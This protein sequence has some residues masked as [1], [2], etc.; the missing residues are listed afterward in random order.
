MKKILFFIALLGG[1]AT[2]AQ[3]PYPDSIDVLHY[4]IHLD[5]GHRTPNRMEGFT[6]VQL[7][8]LK[9]IDSVTLDL[10][11][12]DI[13]S[14][15]VDGSQVGY[16][17][18][19]TFLSIPMPSAAGDTH[20][21]TVHYRK[22]ATVMPQGWGGFYF[23]NDIY[24]NLGIAIYRYPH[25]CGLS[26]F[27]CRDNFYDKATYHFDITSRPG[28]KSIC[29]GMLDSVT[30]H[31]DGS[32]AYSWTLNRP[33]PTYLVGVA[34][35]P[36]HVIQRDF[37]GA[38]GTYP[39]IIGFINHDST[40][41]ADNFAHMD[42][43]IPLLEQRFGPYQWDRV[44][45]VSTPRGSM[46]HVGNVAFVSDCMS[47]DQEICLSTMGHEF[48][49]SWFGN[50][51]TCAT[52]DDMWF[53][54]GGASFCEEITI[55]AI[56]A[57]HNPKRYIAFADE[58][59]F[60]VLL[61]AHLKDDGFRPVYGQ[62]PDHTYGTTVYDKGATVWHSLRGY[63]GDSLF[64][65]SMRTLF[66]R[67]AF[68]TISSRQ[69]CDSLSA[70]SGINL[71]NFFRFHVF[72]AGFNDYEVVD[73]G[74]DFVTLR[75]QSYGTDSLMDGNRVWVTFF[76]DNLEQARRLVCFDGAEM[77][78]PV[79]PLPFQPAFAVVDLDKALSRAAIAT[80]RTAT[81]T[82]PINMP[83]SLFKST[84]NQVPAA[85]SAW[86]L[87]THHWTP[88][89]GAVPANG[90]VR[91]AGHHWTVQGH[92]PYTVLMDG[93]FRY[94]R[95]GSDRSLDENFLLHKNSIDST[96]LL[97]RPD[98]ASPWQ[99]VSTSH[100]GTTS[101]GYLVAP[102][103]QTGEY[104]FAVVDTAALTLAVTTPTPA[105]DAVRLYPNPS[106]GT[107]TISTA[108]P[109]E[110]LLVTVLDLAGRTLRDSLAATSGDSLRLDLPSGNYTLVVR[111]LA[112]G[113]SSSVKI[114]VKNF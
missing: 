94:I 101:Q 70:Y 99:V 35:A 67:C 65:A 60:D 102:T 31:A 27:P 50:L 45:Y 109:G 9:A 8:T 91:F 37:Q 5:L 113:K 6:D 95:S 49:H 18:R 7:R 14:V 108:Q 80:Q 25:N 66:C 55:E 79:A 46:E 93:Q 4:N 52:A 12:A 103:L 28:W 48:A 53:N 105:D 16:V 76:S 61:H 11:V 3:Q 73:F 68:G 59:L 104:T 69:L 36:F 40:A 42:L 106:N 97:Y 98:V 85:D 20:T 107:F 26:W 82:G 17:N 77:R 34:A 57:A 100:T 88:S 54:E 96:V 92:L 32:T 86:L 114:T 15:I 23:E 29:T 87:V 33:T 47:T 90:I 56:N 24:Y 71:H 75:Q 41:V 39:G 13:D 51:I 64:Y 112:S 2:M 58:N 81:A 1:A 111:R 110:A 10:W 74:T 89:I 22:G 83:L 72:N 38:N 19:N 44:G 84:V 43:V 21:V 63:L 62:S 78:C 30:P